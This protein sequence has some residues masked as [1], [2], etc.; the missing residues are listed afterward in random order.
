[1]APPTAILQDDNF[2]VMSCTQAFVRVWVK[3]G[4]SAGI[5]TL[6][7]SVECQKIQRMTLLP[8]G[9]WILGISDTDWAPEL[10]PRL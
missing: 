3:Q 8:D 6:K 4:L 5:A 7:S 10:R 1:M 9:S 2:D